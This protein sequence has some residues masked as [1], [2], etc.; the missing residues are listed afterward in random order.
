MEHGIIAYRFNLDETRAFPMEVLHCVGYRTCPD[1]DELDRAM[2]EFATDPCFGLMG[3]EF[4]VKRAT[5]AQL[6][7]YLG[8]V[9][10]DIFDRADLDDDD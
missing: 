8:E 10:D 6:A 1:D 5:E 7:Y 9:P 4:T 2:R 3:A